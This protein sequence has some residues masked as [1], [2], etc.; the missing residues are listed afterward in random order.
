MEPLRTPPTAHTAR[1]TTHNTEFRSSCRS[2][3]TFS[4]RYTTF[5]A[6]R[7]HRASGVFDGNAE[8]RSANRAGCWDLRDNR[9]AA[10]RKLRRYHRADRRGLLSAQRHLPDT[11]ASRTDT[12]DDLG[13]PDHGGVSRRGRECAQRHTRSLSGAARCRG[14]SLACAR[15]LEKRECSLDQ[16]RPRFIALRVNAKLVSPIVAR[17][18]LVEI[19][20]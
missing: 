19:L 7:R 8:R 12:R 17:L 2:T 13:K 16:P 9:H 3:S 15:S 18:T 10:V 1:S 11:S 4:G 20:I 5:P 6:R 14:V